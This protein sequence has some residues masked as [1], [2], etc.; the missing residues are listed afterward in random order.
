M[1]KDKIK[2]L[3]GLWFLVLLAEIGWLYSVNDR[4]NSVEDLI[5]VVTVIAVTLTLGA[6]GLKLF[7]DD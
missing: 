7:A 5:F 6:V 1:N 4:A 2:G 3:Y